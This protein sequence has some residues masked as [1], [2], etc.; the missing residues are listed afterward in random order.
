MVHLVSVSKGV[1][2]QIKMGTD[3]RTQII[4]PADAQF[5]FMEANIL[6]LFLL[7]QMSSLSQANA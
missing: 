5:E 1:V 4:I 6:F 7:I 3:N 2:L